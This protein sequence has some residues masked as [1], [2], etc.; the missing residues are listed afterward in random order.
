VAF[1]PDGRTVATVGRDQTLCLWDADTGRGRAVVRRKRR[2]LPFP[3]YCFAPDGKTIAFNRDAH[4]ISF[5]DVKSGR[6]VRSLPRFRGEID[7]LVGSPDG[8]LLAVRVFDWEHEPVEK[9]IYLLDPDTGREWARFLDPV[10]SKR[11][12]VDIGGPAHWRWGPVCFSPSGGL[13]ASACRNPTIRLWDLSTGKEIRRLQGHDGYV[14]RASFSPDGR[15]LCSFAVDYDRWQTVP[16]DNTI[17]V[18]QVA[19]GKE[20]SR[21]AA[22]EGTFWQAFSP[23]GRVFACAHHDEGSFFPESGTRLTIYETATGQP[24][25][26]FGYPGSSFR[27]LAFSPRGQELASA[28]EDGT[29]LIWDPTP[30][31]WGPP[32][33]KLS[34]RD[35]DRC[36]RE[37]AGAD[38]R[39]AQRA[40]W[41]LATQ[42]D[43]A[44]AFMGERLAPV[45]GLPPERLRQLIADL[46]SDSFAARERASRDLAGVVLQAEAA[47]RQ[48]LAE[49]KSEEVRRRI[50]P[51]LKLTEKPNE[52]WTVQ[53]P[54]TLRGGRAVWALQRIGTPAARAVLQRLAEG[55]PQARLTQE[56]RA[57]LASLQ[58]CHR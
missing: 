57:A 24:L 55:A 44:T 40:V 10:T 37:L 26:H 1:S 23:D 21:V 8:R 53:D 35:L 38:A 50:P 20:L 17:R 33:M 6:E 16:I 39:A 29:T 31:G 36:W 43:A 2:F 4:T 51:I 34:G 42:A 9:W 3:G 7:S 15:F 27:G 49:T 18:W 48:A 45:P 12:Q 56:A 22:R 30:Q 58:D 46:D 14:R 19:T 32:K 11:E 47:L 5:H 28:M 52:K 54:E 25:L 41:T 13:L